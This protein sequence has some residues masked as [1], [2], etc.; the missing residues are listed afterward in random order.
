MHSRQDEFNQVVEDMKNKHMEEIWKINDVVH[1]VQTVHN[2]GS[3]FSANTIIAV[4]III[5]LLGKE[6]ARSFCSPGDADM[7]IAILRDLN[8]SLSKT[9]LN[10][11]EILGNDADLLDLEPGDQN[12]GKNGKKLE[13][14]LLDYFI[15]KV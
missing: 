5:V 3:R 2:S 9:D 13:K 10:K 12:S 4:W 7:I 15:K 11:K 8:I 14:I 6:K 1:V